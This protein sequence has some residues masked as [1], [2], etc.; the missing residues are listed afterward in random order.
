MQRWKHIMMHINDVETLSSGMY[1]YQLIPLTWNSYVNKAH[2]WIVNDILRSI[3]MC[4]W[5]FVQEEKGRGCSL[6]FE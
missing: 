5:L 3:I 4:V 6:D 2:L 1:V